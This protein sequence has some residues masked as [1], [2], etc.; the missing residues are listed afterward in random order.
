[1]LFRSGVFKKALITIA[2]EADSFDVDVV[3][4]YIDQIYDEPIENIRITDVI[5]DQVHYV[6]LRKN[7]EKSIAVK[8]LKAALHQLSRI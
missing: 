3:M 4:G 7:L 5:N 1:M 8:D 6:D 2:R